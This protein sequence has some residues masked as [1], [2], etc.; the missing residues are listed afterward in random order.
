MLI[1]MAGLPGTGKTTLAYRL[2]EAMAGVVLSK[3]LVRATLFPPQVLDYSTEQDDLTMRAIYAAAS[4]IHRSRPRCPVLIDGRTFS[5]AYQMRDFL[6]A[7][8]EA[9]G[10][11]RVIE[12]ICA[13]GIA[14]ARLARDAAT[15]NH[16]AGNRTPELYLR[17]K[18]RAEP[19][20]IPRLVLDTGNTTLAECLARSIAYLQ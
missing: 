3:D 2:A 8:S 20:T 9:G 4:S 18:A 16:P 6:Q 13:D 12:C 14:Q 1:A 17:A 11:W 19:L 15:G 10:E 5:R 7:A